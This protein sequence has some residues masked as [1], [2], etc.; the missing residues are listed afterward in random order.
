MKIKFK[1]HF[2]LLPFV[3]LSLLLGIW[4]G[5]IRI[6]WAFPFV[7]QSPVHGALMVGS[8]LSTLISLERTVTNPRKIFLLVPLFNL[9][10]L[11]AF[12]ANEYS[13]G[14]LFLVVGSFGLCIVYLLLYFKFTE[15]YMLMLLSGGFCL[16]IGNVILLKSNMYFSAVMWWIAFLYFTIAGERIELTKYLNIKNYVKMVLIFFLLLYLIAI[17]I[18]FHGLGGY[19]AGI[20]M[21]GSTLWLFKYDMAFK[22]LKA[23]GQHRYTGI[24]LITGY[25]WLF[26]TGVFMIYGASSAFLYDAVLHSFFI[27]FIFSMIFAHAPII[28]PGVIGVPIKPF[29]N[30]LYIWFVLLQLSLILRIS[31]VFTGMSYYKQLGGLLNGIAIIGFFINMGI[32]FK[33]E[34]RKLARLYNA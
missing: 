17:L 10:S 16:L 9:L 8:F 22:S 2:L 19:V 25:I 3:M 23:S 7:S 26:I 27:G 32:V 28:L 14:Y 6:G 30:S 4:T 29:N 31:V 13:I 21:I 18:P 33:L 24:L 11:F 34:K 15:M 12:L 20:S 5:W 1:P